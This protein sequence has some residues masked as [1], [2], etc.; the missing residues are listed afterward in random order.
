MI[1]RWLQSHPKSYYGIFSFFFRVRLY[2]LFIVYVVGVAIAAAS[3]SQFIQIEYAGPKNAAPGCISWFH[4]FYYTATTFISPGF[5]EFLPSDE[6]SRLASLIGG[7]FGVAYNAL[8]FSILIARALQP[9]EPFVVVP[10]LL[11]HPVNK[12]LTARLY[13]A[14][15]SAA[16]NL[17]MRFYRFMIYEN[18]KTNAQMGRT[19]EIETHPTDRNVL[20]PNYGL[21][22]SIHMED[23]FSP[24]QST[25]NRTHKRK[26]CPIEWSL[27]VGENNYD[28]H[29]YLT[30]E[31]E[32]PYGKMFQT[33]YFY[34]NK[35]QL[36]CGTH[37]LLNHETKLTLNNWYKWKEYRWD[38]WGKYNPIPREIIKLEANNPLLEAYCEKGKS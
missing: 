19:I 12:T 15:P 27:P 20:L 10:F 35:S 38:L 37:S 28:G 4:I 31:A 29:F 33:Q 18:E 24:Q 21:L 26:K 23:E 17:R 13:S 34:L 30:I 25:P 6:I 16:Y 5:T 2:V 11:Y 32:T 8:F 1:H 7:A 3:L 22:V 14:L 36:K 9:H